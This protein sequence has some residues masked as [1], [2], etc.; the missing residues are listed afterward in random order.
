MSGLDNNAKHPIT[1]AGCPWYAP[2]II[3][4][5]ALSHHC[6]GAPSHSA[7]PQ[8]VGTADGVGVTNGNKPGIS[9]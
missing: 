3:S 7:I 4:Y 8:A 2:A 5:V 1:P 9:S 6:H